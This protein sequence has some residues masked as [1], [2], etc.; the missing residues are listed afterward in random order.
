[1]YIFVPLAVYPSS[2]CCVVHPPRLPTSNMYH[3]ISV[4]MRTYTA[5]S[6]RIVLPYRSVSSDSLRTQ[7]LRPFLLFASLV[8]F[9]FLG[10]F[11]RPSPF[12]L[13]ATSHRD[14]G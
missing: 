10:G 7:T 6:Y 2:V 8:L 4:S 11:C 12:P 9:S 13:P 5:N 3:P 14:R 1:M